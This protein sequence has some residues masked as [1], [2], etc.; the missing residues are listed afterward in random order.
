VIDPVSRG[1]QPPTASDGP[2]LVAG[3]DGSEGAAAAVRWA[4][5]RTAPS[6]RLVVVCAAHPALPRL[7]V[8]ARTAHAKA[9]LEALWMTEDVLVDADAELVVVDG[10]PA[11]V[12]CE[13]ASE[14]QADGIV[15]GRHHD[16]PFNADTVRHVLQLTDRPVTVVPN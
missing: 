8:A 1:D 16:G 4:A 6:G 7:A 5:A 14:A 11:T 2:T 9:E 12:L 3:Y 13:A 10:L 15:V